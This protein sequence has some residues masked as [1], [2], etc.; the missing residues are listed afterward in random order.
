M[1]NPQVNIQSFHGS[2]KGNS[3][4]RQSAGNMSFSLFVIP[5]NTKSTKT[6]FPQNKW[7]ISWMCFL[8]ADP[9]SMRP[10][11]P[12][13]HKVPPKETA[14]VK[15]WWLRFLHNLAHQCLS[16]LINWWK[17][18]LISLVPSKKV[19]ESLR[20]AVHRSIN[21]WLIFTGQISGRQ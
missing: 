3:W 15:N 20:K 5:A 21:G 1:V 13:K 2:I 19:A 10:V 9:Y 17:M 16:E 8:T 18:S 11:K 6:W 12:Q 14:V 7:S 4:R